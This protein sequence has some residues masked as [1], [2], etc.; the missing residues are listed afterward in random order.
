MCNYISHWG[1]D[2]G[3]S[4]GVTFTSQALL[5]YLGSVFSPPPSVNVPPSQS[6]GEQLPPG[7]KASI[8][9]IGALHGEAM[10]VWGTQVRTGR[11]E[12]GC[13]GTLWEGNDGMGNAGEDRQRVD[14]ERGCAEGMGVQNRGV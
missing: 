6:Q 14:A 10:M 3:A 4:L 1:Y 8:D 11:P 13:W 5:F 2:L 9:N 12:G 7:V